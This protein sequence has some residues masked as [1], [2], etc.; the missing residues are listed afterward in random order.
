MQFNKKKIFVIAGEI[1]GDNIAYNLLSDFIKIKKYDIKGVGG[2]KLKKL[3]MSSIFQMERIS[4]MGILEI[5]PK[6]P[7]LLFLLRKTIIEIIKYN[8]DLL[9]TIDSPG[10]NFRI[11]KK[12]KKLDPNIKI[13]HVVAPTVWAW[14]ASRAKKNI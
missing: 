2:Q 5:V 9:I 14:K 3:G 1:S 10:F 13:L 6:I 8:P 12:I 4:L 11:A 7:F